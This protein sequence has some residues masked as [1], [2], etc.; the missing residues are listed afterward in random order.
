M[1]ILESARLSPTSV[2]S[3][4]ES[5]TALIPVKL[6]GSV[7]HLL[8]THKNFIADLRWCVDTGNKDAAKALVQR[9]KFYIKSRTKKSLGDRFKYTFQELIVAGGQEE[10]IIVKLV[11][12]DH[13]TFCA[14]IGSVR[15]MQKESEIGKTVT[16]PCVMPIVDFIVIE[17]ESDRNRGVLISPL[18]SS[19]IQCFLESDKQIQER[20]LASILLCGLSGI[21]SFALRNIHHCDI[22]LSN[23]MFGL[24]KRFVLIDFGSA[25][26]EDEIISSCTYGM[27][28]NRHSPT[29]GYDLACLVTTVMQLMYEEFVTYKTKAHVHQQIDI[30]HD[31]FPIFC[32]MLK[33]LPI[34]DEVDMNEFIT[35]V[36]SLFEIAKT[37]ADFDHSLLELIN[38]F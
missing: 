24:D 28:I 8:S 22:K 35:I 14:K 26:K 3:Y 7:Q 19:S 10:T 23:I 25:T 30:V 20:V 27:S 12:E 11:D 18:Y 32:T 38:I 13:K 34:D 4:I 15:Q 1:L 29:I 33:M 37:I 6:D 9:A 16:G 31:R 17:K 21:C 2:S 36:K 5:F